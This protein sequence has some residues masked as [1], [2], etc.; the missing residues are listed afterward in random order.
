MTWLYTTPLIV[1]AAAMVVALLAALELGRRLGR[2]IQVRSAQASVVA[3]PILGLVALLLAF[4][5]SLASER[6]ARRRAAAVA[7]ANSIGT[8]WLRTSLLPEPTRSE[9]RTRL[10]RYVDVHFEHRAAAIDERRTDAVEAEVNRLQGELW[11]LLIEDARRDPESTRLRL[12]TP[13]LNAMID[14]TGTL[15]AAWENRVP[16]AVLMYLFVLVLIAALVL[17][18]RPHGETQLVASGRVRRPHDGCDGHT[19]RSGSTSPGAHPG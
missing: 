8:M 17:G 13:A 6:H 7:E 3:G 11:A 1:L 19:P 9:M 18:Y 4:S 2:V 14:D 5:F 10:Q 12:V 16:D 15:L